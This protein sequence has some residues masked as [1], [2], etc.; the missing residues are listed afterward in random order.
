MGHVVI[1]GAGPAGASLAYLLSRRGVE[2]TL[3]ERQTKFEREFRGEVLMPS[4]SVALH[5]MGLGEALADLPSEPQRSVSL[6]MNGELVFSEEVGGGLFDSHPARAVSQ[7]HLLEMLVAR[8]AESP[9]FHFQ[10]GVSVKELLFEGDRVVGVRARSSD[11]EKR[12]A[13]DLV[14]GADGR[15]SAVRKHGDFR[16]ASVSPPLDIVWCKLPCPNGWAGARAYMGRGHFLV[17]YRSWDGMLQL[18]WAIRKGSFGALKSRGIDGWLQEMAAHVSQDLAVHIRDYGHCAKRP[19]LL[20]SVSDCVESWSVPGALLIGDAAHTMSPVG[21]QGV[22]IA[23]RDAITA[24]NHLVPVLSSIRPNGLCRALSAIEEER[25]PEVAKIQ[26]LQ[27]F[28]PKVGFNTAWWGEPLRK[29]VSVLAANRRIR[30]RAATRLAEFPFGVTKV[31][32]EV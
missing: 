18:G 14:V 28:P 26:R 20:D 21:G 7:P 27:G 11:G 15:A 2:V 17:G 23:L 30:L 22:N 1:V 12:I 29:I 4:G 9:R 8:S 25:M 16:A 10:S 31:Q 13:S 19:F 24:A 3:L 5:E 6:Y 32:L